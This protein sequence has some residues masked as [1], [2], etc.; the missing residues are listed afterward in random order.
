MNETTDAATIFAPLWRRKW[1]ILIVGVLVAGATYT[2]YKRQPTVYSATT[3]IDLGSGSEEQQLINS[4]QGKTTL[5]AHALADAATLITSSVVAE[6][7]EARLRK[8]GVHVGTHG[9]V[10]AKTTSTSDF[11]TI[12]AEAHTAK[13]AVRLANAYAVVYL[14]RQHAHYQRA[15]EAAITNTRRQLRRIEAGQAASSGASKGKGGKASGAVSGSATI[16]AA[17]LASKINQLESELSVSSAQQVNPA[18]LRSAQLL[19]PTPKKNAIFGFVLGILL[20]AIA[21]FAV[22]RF[23]RR[24][25]SLG[26]IETIFKTQILAALPRAR[27]PIAYPDGQPQPARALLEPLRRLHTSLQLG[28]MLEHD[29]EAA[30]RLILFLS[31]DAGDGKSTLIADLALVQRDAG[32]R[33]AVLEADLRRPI[34]AGLLSASASSGLAEVLAGAVSYGEAMQRVQS[35]QP[36]A[37]IDSAQPVAGVSTVLQSQS[38][39]SLSVLAAGGPAANPPALLASAAMQDLLRSAAA[40]FDYVLIDAPP[41]LQVSDAMPLLHTVDGLVIVARSEH[42][43]EASAERLMQLLAHTATA[44]VLGVVANGVSRADLKRY[45]FSSGHG[46]RRWPRNPIAK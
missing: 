22:G 38:T 44:P 36:E 5:S 27:A 39:G 31:A 15:V 42:T 14:A 8:E 12:T 9:K 30:P 37:D 21:A 32:A 23:D 28:D 24:I 29:R 11:V 4:A 1:L 46:D 6:A 10:H 3:Q 17:S 45:G 2:Y 25:R 20:A 26:Q 16:Q 19:S 41:P 40:D 18:K 13:A 35:M 43:R 34:Q 33:V 7:V